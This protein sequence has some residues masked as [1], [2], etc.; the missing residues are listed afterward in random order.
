MENNSQFSSLNSQ[1]QNRA[2]V[3]L[4]EDNAGLNDANTQA[5]KLRGY[6]VVTAENLAEARARLAEVQP[7]VIL[8]DVMLPDG[9]GFD[10]CEEIR[11]KTNAYILFLTALAS[12]EDMVQGMTGGGDAYITKP[13]HP[14]E[15]LVKVDAAIRRKDIEKAPVK[16][17]SLGN[18][19][20]D[21]VS[22]QAYVDSVDLL[23]TKKEFSLLLVFAQNEGVIL[24]TEYLF[25]QVWNLPIFVY[26]LTV[27]KHISAL[28][29]KLDAGNC[30]HTVTTFYGKGYCF[31]LR[32]RE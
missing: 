8:L 14:E 7:D 30:S 5:L 25:S 9:S 12:H 27:R 4:V 23:L 24:N 31:K 19:S 16:T 1:L 13:F 20:L 3:L 10:F 15:M 28:R 21:I 2:T 11:G 29:N 22:G 18:L 26:D 32:G 17:L 6:T